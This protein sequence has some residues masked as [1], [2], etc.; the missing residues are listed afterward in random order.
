MNQRKHVS[1]PTQAAVLAECRRRCAIC[2]GLDGDLT[3]KKGQIAHLDHDPTNSDE[4]NLVF[5]CFDHH[6]EYDSTTRQSKNLTVIEVARYLDELKKALTARWD[7]IVADAAAQTDP[8]KRSSFAD[9]EWRRQCGSRLWAAVLALRDGTPRVLYE[10]DVVLES[11]YPTATRS[12]AFGSG[13]RAI[14]EDAIA[15]G[16]FLRGQ[17]ENVEELRPHLGEDLWHLFASYQA[18]VGRACLVTAGLYGTSGPWYRDSLALRLLGQALSPDQAL[19]IREMSLGR[20]AAAR[21]SFEDSV[22]AE[23]RTLTS[24]GR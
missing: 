16:V 23:I 22:L 3:R 12:A 4:R 15:R 2:F 14:T 10:L 11:E 9:T 20:L 17:A 6:D 21:S 1:A 13:V 8:E 19:R 18:F 24:P 7:T 5:L